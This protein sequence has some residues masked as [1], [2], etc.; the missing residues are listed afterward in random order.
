MPEPMT[1]IAVSGGMGMLAYYARRYYL[2]AK[3]VLDIV[4]GTVGLIAALPIMAICAAIIKLSSRGPVV[5][6][7]TR[8]GKDGKPFRMLKFRTMRDGAEEDTGAVW[9][10]DDD[11]RVIPACRWMRI[12]HMD[13]L[14]QL[15][16]VVAGTMSLIGPRPERPEILADLESKYPNVRYRLTVKPGITGLAQVRNGYDTSVDAFGRKLEADTE[17]IDH[18]CWSQDLKILAWTITKLFDRKAR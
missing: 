15:L 4:L 18:M 17:Y 8:A 12:S 7:Q 1:I 9:A 6:S 2:V 16:H 13:E 3:E 11:P 10:S 14:P 5:F